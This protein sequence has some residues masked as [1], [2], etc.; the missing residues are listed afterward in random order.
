MQFLLGFFF[1]AH[2]EKND[3]T[4]FLY[5]LI[6]EYCIVMCFPKMYKDWP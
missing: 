1:I 2:V 5:L 4:G 6:A 3:M